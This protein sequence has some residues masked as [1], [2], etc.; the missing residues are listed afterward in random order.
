MIKKK[1]WIT[2][3]VL[4]AL[5]TS[6]V[7][8]YASMRNNLIDDTNDNLFSDV[9]DSDWFSSDVRY[10]NEKGLMSG[11]GET[12]FSPN[13]TMTRAM[14][15]T[16][17]WRLEGQPT[18]NNVTFDDVKSDAYYYN[19]VAW[20]SANKIVSGYDEKTF[21]SD[22]DVTREQ[23]AAIFYRFAGHKG[24]DVSKN[25]D[26]SKYT[27]SETI[28][29]YAV[30]AFEW[31]I[32][33]GII[34]GTSENT[35]S[36]Q[37]NALR[38]QVAAILKRFCN[39]YHTDNDKDTGSVIKNETVT[40]GNSE[41]SNTGSNAGSKAISDSGSKMIENSN[42][43]FIT[44]SEATALPGKDVRI[45]ANIENN[46]GILGM[47]LTLNFDET[48]LKLEKAE[49]GNAFRDVLDFTPSKTLSSG[50]RFVW[51]GVDITND[52]IKDGEILIM[53][54]HILENAESGKYPIYLN[55]AD[56]D[57]VDNNLQAVSVTIEIGYIIVE[58]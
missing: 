25:A 8:V 37:G 38:C 12:V 55:C 43:P 53:D 1:M 14:V 9:S 44:I 23:L 39:V 16:V 47:T 54:F 40:S 20:A 11:T 42:N 52:K 45:I 41:K 30:N 32:A 18:G 28:S 31:T 36:P 21:G 10:V 17:L 5:C 27:D 4:F 33:N 35:I 56:G 34:T 26:L 3:F 29:D 19:A 48:A 7:I 22:D 15:V 13:E 58:K 2:V 24:Y 57:I 50:S 51:D 46:P 49:S 6:L